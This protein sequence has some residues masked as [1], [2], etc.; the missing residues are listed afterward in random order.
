MPL[1]PT[2]PAAT[3]PAADVHTPTPR[4]VLLGTATALQV[5]RKAASVS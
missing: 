1:T 5:I 4:P 2:A 3:A